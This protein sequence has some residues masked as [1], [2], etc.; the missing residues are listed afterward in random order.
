MLDGEPGVE[1]LDRGASWMHGRTRP[2]SASHYVGDI[3]EPVE[4]D[5]DGKRLEAPFFGT[6]TDTAASAVLLQRRLAMMALK[7]RPGRSTR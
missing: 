3:A 6:N 4:A 2:L 7:T 1:P 5:D